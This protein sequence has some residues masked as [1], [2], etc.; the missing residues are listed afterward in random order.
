MSG[1]NDAAAQGA[2]EAAAAAAARFA[3]G[4]AADALANA[5]NS[6]FVLDKRAFYLSRAKRYSEAL[7]LLAVLRY[8]DPGGF[9]P[10]YLTGYQY[11]VQELYS[12]AI[13][14]F[15]HALARQPGHVK[16]HWR[17]AKA[18]A[19]TG[20]P[21]EACAAAATVLRLFHA[22]PDSEKPAQ[23]QT[24]GKASHM[25]GKY[26]LEKG[27]A[28]D[29]I[30]FLQQAVQADN[31]DPYHHYLLGKAQFRT[32]CTSDAIIAL[33]KARALKR[34]DPSIELELAACLLQTGDTEG[35]L[36]AIAR[37]DQRC[38]GW[39][40]YK[41]G[42]LALESG[43]PQLA[44][45][46]LERANQ[47]RDTHGSPEVQQALSKALEA[48]GPADLNNSATAFGKVAVVN[49]QRGFGFLVDEHGVRRHFRLDDAR[50]RKGDRVRFLPREASKGPA[51]QDVARI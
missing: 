22:L 40:A 1:E 8:R 48:A 41:A 27:R 2:I 23:Q 14:W 26:E 9:M 19:A 47:N 38:R 18:L 20:R 45:R 36:T 34:D 50:L 28:R 33:R 44:V 11:Y 12:E 3:W 16:A 30:D 29:A 39:L 46:I 51:A 32:G 13:P 17:K 7:E 24:F 37:V 25:L 49:P 42:K 5:G 10:L 31:S 35:C 15:D 21:A 43:R 4:Q 6:T